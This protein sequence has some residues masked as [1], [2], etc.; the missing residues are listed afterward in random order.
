MLLVLLKSTYRFRCGPNFGG[1]CTLEAPC[2]YCIMDQKEWEN[3]V[4]R[5]WKSVTQK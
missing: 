5:S 3:F 2:K 4:S 1:I